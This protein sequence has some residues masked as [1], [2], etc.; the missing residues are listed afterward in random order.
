[1]QDLKKKFTG[2]LKNIDEEKLLFESGKTE[3]EIDFNSI[4]SAKVLISF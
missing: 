2:K 3:I 1:E 4:K